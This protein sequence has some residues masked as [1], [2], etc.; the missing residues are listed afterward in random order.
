MASPQSQSNKMHWEAIAANAEQPRTPEAVIEYNETHWAG[1]TAEPGGVDYIETDAG[2]VP[3]MWIA[4]KGAIDDRVIVYSHGGGFISGSIY[5][6]RKLVGHLAKAVGCRA[7]IYEYPYAH[8]AKH[9]AQL[10]TALRAYH[11]LLSQDLPSNHI[12]MA[13]DSAGAILTFGVLQRIREEGLS[14]PAAILIMSGWMDMAQTAASYETNRDK[15]LM[16]SKAATAWLVSNVMGDGNRRDPLV[17]AVYADFKGFPPI[18]L[19]AG[20]DEALA[21][22]SRMLAERAKQAGVEVRL[23]IFPEMLHTF[24]MMAGRAPEADEAIRR[25]ADWVR[26]KLDL[27]VNGSRRVRVGHTPTLT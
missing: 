10:E 8:Q 13:G 18:F 6:H 2:G 5:T 25:F 12:A 11:W 24:Q 3:A 15:D 9:P 21:D 20:A 22:E 23:D 4:P 19:Q 16:F 14:F 27:N 17:S 1:L 7:L 26:P